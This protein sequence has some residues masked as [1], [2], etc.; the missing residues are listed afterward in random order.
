M[1]AVSI[2][3]SLV[4][5]YV[6]FKGSRVWKYWPFFFLLG[7]LVIGGCLR[8]YRLGVESIWLDEY[9][10]IRYAIQPN[11]S[12]LLTTLNANT[13]HPPLYFLL[14]HFWLQ[15]GDTDF[16]L[17][18]PS[19][20]FGTLSIAA[21]YFTA[22]EM[23]DRRVGL[24]SALLLA[25]SPMHLWHGQDARMYTLLVF[26]ILSS[27]CF[28]WAAWQKNKAV[29]WAAYVV[30][31]T[32][33]L[34]THYLAIPLLAIQNVFVALS[35]FTDRANRR[36]RI[37]RWLI[38]QIVVLLFFLPWPLTFW[39]QTRIAAADTLSWI[40]ELHGRPTLY[41][42]VLTPVRFSFGYEARSFYPPWFAMAC[43]AVLAFVFTLGALAKRNSFPFFS[44]PRMGAVL[45]TLTSW[46]VPIIALWLFS[47]IKPLFIARYT[48]VYSP[49]FYILLARG[50]CTI[51]PHQ[52]QAMMV[53]VVIS[54]FGCYAIQ[55]HTHPR[56]VPWREMANYV[57]GG[58]QSDDVV[59]LLAD[60]KTGWLFSYY[61]CTNIPAEQ[62]RWPEKESVLPPDDLNTWLDDSTTGHDRVWFIYR[63]RPLLLER[64]PTGIQAYLGS[65]FSLTRR[66]SF[67]QKGVDEFDVVLYTRTLDKLCSVFQLEH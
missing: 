67:G 15:P 16:H 40:A 49:F 18:L 9:Y 19:A 21:L 10:S 42:L 7:T 8:L 39:D 30:A 46:V 65:Q 53:L 20:L 51:R 35:L 59:L 64:D 66:R 11:V 25:L 31:A 54:I 1:V 55:Y 6:D 58:W 22:T 14:L 4:Q 12:S 17:R 44:L 63:Q 2:K 13:V 52:A 36:R 26:A 50:L 34:Y 41:K 47:Q 33:S 57:A 3:T 23:F 38:A 48:F 43:F 27:S 29:A 37:L 28:L 62:I 61:A 45:F 5:R 56:T 24:L 32:V 60:R